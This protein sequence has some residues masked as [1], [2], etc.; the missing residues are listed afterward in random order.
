MGNIEIVLSSSIA[1]VFVAA[2][3]VT[4]TMW[5]RSTATPIKLFGPTH[6]Q[7]DQGYF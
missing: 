3:V 4:G 1:I 7:W 2:F 6:Y 5:H